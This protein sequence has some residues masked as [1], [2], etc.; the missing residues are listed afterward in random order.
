MSTAVD[1]Q[2]KKTTEADIVALLR[3]RYCQDAG[4]GPAAVLIPQVRNAAGFDATRTA[5]A[6][7]MQLW[8]S[9]GL[10]LEGFEIKCSRADV[11]KE[12]KQPEKAEV[13][14]RWCERWW[15][16]IADASFLKDGE[17]PAEWGLLVR[18]GSR[19]ICQKE[20]P[21]RDVP[22]ELP[23]TFL[24]ALLRQVDRELHRPGED[25]LRAEYERGVKSG[26]ASSGWDGKE[27]E[28]LKAAVA[29][30][31]ELAGVKIGAGDARLRNSAAAVRLVLGGGRGWDSLA[32]KLTGLADEATKIVAM[33]N[34]SG[35]PDDPKYG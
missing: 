20:A 28:R 33:I 4:N 21:V 29:E 9:R 10:H 1:K 17:L 18:H 26:E 35:L 22:K 30:F 15:L 5:D 16:V 2:A 14:A 23:K 11:L 31:E 8:P 13:I 34:E 6:L 32:N 12:L 3:K 24:A 27:L 7:A 25:A 19:L